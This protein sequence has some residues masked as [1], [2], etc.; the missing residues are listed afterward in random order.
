MAFVELKEFRN[1][2]EGPDALFLYTAEVAPIFIPLV[3]FIFFIIVLLGTFFSQRRLTGRGDFAASFVVAGFAT[4]IIAI[5]MTIVEGLINTQ[6]VV[7]T[8]VIAI[9]GGYLV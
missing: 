5:F 9:I 4:A 2:S 1:M 8:V 6:T 3:L 7:I